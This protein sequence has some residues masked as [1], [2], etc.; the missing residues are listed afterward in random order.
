[1]PQ[2][3]KQGIDRCFTQELSYV[4]V[5]ASSIKINGNI[6]LCT[7]WHY[8]RALKKIEFSLLIKPI[9][10]YNRYL[11]SLFMCNCNQFIEIHKS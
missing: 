10:A 8:F 4:K 3:T 11:V 9:T 7:F 1:M 6:T 2:L 5:S